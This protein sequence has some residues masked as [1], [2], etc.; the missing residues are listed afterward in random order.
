[1]VPLENETICYIEEKQ[2]TVTTEYMLNL[3]NP[4]NQFKQGIK[5]QRNSQMEKEILNVIFHL[6]HYKPNDSS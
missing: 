6:E 1:M 3:Q 4:S 2:I 5:N